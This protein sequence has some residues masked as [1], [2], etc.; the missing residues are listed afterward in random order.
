MTMMFSVPEFFVTAQTKEVAIGHFEESDG[1]RFVTEN[2]VLKSADGNDDVSSTLVYKCRV[3]CS[4]W[5]HHDGCRTDDPTFD[6]T[7]IGEEIPKR[8]SSA[9]S[10][11]IRFTNTDDILSKR[12][13][14]VMSADR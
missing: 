5:L 3:T 4:C 7:R 12:F 10:K 1:G 14:Q 8:R 2:M 11:S 6:Q 13:V 9:A